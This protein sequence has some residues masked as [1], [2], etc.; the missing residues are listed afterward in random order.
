MT[1]WRFI[2]SFLYVR[3]WHTGQMELSRPRVALFSASLFL[4]VLALTLITVLQAPI[5]YQAP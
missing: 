5:D 1:F 4:M 2:F 3:D